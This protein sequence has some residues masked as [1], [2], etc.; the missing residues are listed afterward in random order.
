MAASDAEA[1]GGA[2]APFFPDVPGHLLVR[3]VARYQRQGTWPVDPMLDPPEYDGLQDILLAAGMVK[4]RQP[5][6]KVVRPEFV[7]SPG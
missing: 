3:S 7:V 2:V 4:E 6:P 5:Y 1:V